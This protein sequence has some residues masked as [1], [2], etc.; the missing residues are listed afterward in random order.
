MSTTPLGGA[1][2]LQPEDLSRRYLSKV[3]PRLNHEQALELAL[4][5]ARL[6]R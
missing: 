3:D 4:R 5:V 2:H 6:A 1:R